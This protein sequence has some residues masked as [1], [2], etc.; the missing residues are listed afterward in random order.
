MSTGT[1]EIKKEAVILFAGDSGDGIQ[2]T[3]SQFTGTAAFYGNDVSTFP[4]FPAEIRAPQGTLAGVSG[5]QLH[6]GSME[7]NS[8]G[9]ACDVLVVMNAAA[10][11]ANLRQLKKHGTIIANTDG[12]DPKNLKLA[13]YADGD[14]PLKNGSLSDYHVIG[15]DVTK[16]TR[17]AL[18]G[19]GLGTKETD[20]SKNMF[21]LGFIYWMYN[22]KPDL[23][24]EFLKEQFKKRPELIDANVKV[25]MAGYHYGDTTETPMTRY[26]IKA[27]NL[28]PGTYRSITGNQG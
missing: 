5:F 17:N 22:R 15:I 20:R 21:V 1:Q 6:F 11:K 14:N 9:D 23:T 24:V 27:A 10:L 18:S 7:I 26:E 2:L 16:L 8:P 4:N 28:P 19:S 3:G 25:L 13:K 12:F